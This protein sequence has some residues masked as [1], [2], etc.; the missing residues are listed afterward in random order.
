MKKYVLSIVIV[1][2]VVIALGTAS[3]VSA[4]SSTY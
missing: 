1:A 4:Q 3:F 2:V